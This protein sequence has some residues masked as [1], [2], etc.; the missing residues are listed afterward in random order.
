MAMKLHRW[1]D[2]KAA[3]YTPEEIAELKAQAAKEREEMRQRGLY[4]EADSTPA[5]IAEHQE[6]P[7]GEPSEAEPTNE[8]SESAPPRKR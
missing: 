1:K 6:P 3:R 5:D 2:V 8:S 7:P 4:E